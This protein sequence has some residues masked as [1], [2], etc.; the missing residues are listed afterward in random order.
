MYTEKRLKEKFFGS[1]S[2]ALCKFKGQYYINGFCYEDNKDGTGRLVAG[3]KSYNSLQEA[4]SEFRSLDRQ[5]KV[6]DFVKR[7]ADYG[8]T[9]EVQSPSEDAKV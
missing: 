8:I 6:K 2:A 3:R 9:D 5:K 7:N 4:E 1:S